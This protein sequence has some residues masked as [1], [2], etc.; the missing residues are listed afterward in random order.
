MK[1]KILAGFAKLRRYVKNHLGIS[2]TVLLLSFFTGVFGATIAII[3]KNLLYFTTNILSTAFPHAQMNYL[4]LAFPLVGIILTMLYV[5]RVVK[6]DL[7][8][9]VSIALKSMC[10]DGGKL[11]RHN[12]YSSMI[13]SSITVGFGG[14]VG[15]EAPIVLTGS[16]AGSNLAQFFNLSSKNTRLLLACGSAAAMAAIF[17]A[18]IAGIVFSI[19]VLM[20]DLTAAAILPLLISAATGTVLSILFLGENVMFHETLTTTFV[21]GN[22][23]YYIIL[24]ILAGLLAVFFMRTLRKIEGRFK[25][26]GNKWAKAIIGGLVLGGLIFVFPVFY[27]EGYE[28]INHILNGDIY[29]LF[30]NSPLY[31]FLNHKIF[32]YIFILAVI[33]LKVVASA[34]TTASG[35]VGGVFAPTL[36]VGAFLG[37][38]IAG[39]FNYFFNLG[40]PTANFVLAGM[41]GVMSGVMHAPLTGIFLIAELSTGYSL[42]IPLMFTSSLAYITCKRFE[43]HSV[44]T[45]SL[46]D[47]GDLITHNKDK[48]AMQKLNWRKL[49]DKNI[50]TI[51]INATLREYTDAIAK[52]KRNIFVVL[53]E[54][55]LFAGLL[56]MDN[57]R[58][59]LFKPDL[60]D[61]VLVKDLMIQPEAV[62]YD[63]DTGADIIEKF[64]KTNYFNLPVI[65][66]GRKYI[67]FLSKAK[68]LSDYKEFIAEESED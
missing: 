29:A 65:T 32:L 26:I 14:S 52:S 2:G 59:I 18:P 1:K 64:K 51:S 48:F 68:M 61:S 35:G 22:T 58:D 5:T 10:R 27:G 63:T 39:I 38:F 42:L 37:F 3:I 43:K 21:V 49:I 15:L 8:H 47:V 25:K 56:D 4:Y 60:Y 40:L 55:N 6:D 28:N 31:S 20:L 19:E 62:G 33:L 12:I 67:G 66:T 30:N 41:A 11:R 54:Q 53:D 9:G 13:A 50:S 24:G 57:H 34:L 16:A 23:P 44:Y 36:F 45:K 46:A 7:S 17:K